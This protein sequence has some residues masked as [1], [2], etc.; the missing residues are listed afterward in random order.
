VTSAPEL[1]QEPFVVLA[2][3][4]ADRVMVSWG[5]FYLQRT[6]PDQR[7]VVVEDED[8]PRLVGRRTCIGAGAEPFGAAVVVVR[9][10]DGAVVAS[11]RTDER[12]WVWVRGLEPDTDYSYSVTVDGRPWAEGELWDTVADPRGGYDLR[13]SARS[14]DLRFRTWPDPERPS[15]A[16]SF[17]ALGDYGVGTR[18]DSESSRRQRRVAEVLEH[19]VGEGQVR[20]VL[21]LGDNIYEGELG[22]VGEDSGGED[23]DWYSSFYAPYRYVL[24]RVPF[25]PVV[26]N[27]DT[28]EG[29][30]S[31]DRAQLEDNFHLR[32]RLREQEG[33]SSVGPGLFYRARLGRDVEL[34]A[35]DTSVDTEADTGTDGYPRYFQLPHHRRWLEEVFAA[36]DVRWRIP[37]SHHPAY[38]AG[39]HHGDDEDICTDLVPLFAAGGVRLALA[40]HEHNFQLTEVDGLTYVVSGAGGSLREEPPGRDQARP[41]AWAGQAHLLLVE[42]D[43][44]VARL[45]PLSGLLPDGGPHLMTALSPAGEVLRPP[46]LVTA[47]GTRPTSVSAPPGRATRRA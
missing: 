15:P 45:S 25:L 32:E 47:A 31:D 21:S 39:P 16:L 18:S 20:L 7:W 14:Y 11:A 41:L 42:I 37:F 8:L 9:D 40:G 46:F 33:R 24:A 34:V 30:R 23:D 5:A 12:T 38:C 4:A 2:D 35:V 13:P 28:A 17:V 27:H 44:E 10:G 3:L 29:G 43:G 22:E 6:G 1:R 36:A 26:G 19:L